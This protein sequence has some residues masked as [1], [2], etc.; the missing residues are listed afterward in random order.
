MGILFHH[1]V[2]TL[3]MLRYDAGE[4]VAFNKLC[5]GGDKSSFF[6]AIHVLIGSFTGRG[7]SHEEFCK[8][9]VFCSILRWRVWI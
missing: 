9:I 3:V 8:A 4:K 1:T 5:E 2:F 6:V 7:L